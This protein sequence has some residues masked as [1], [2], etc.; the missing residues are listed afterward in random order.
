MS[1]YPLTPC[2]D[3]PDRQIGCHGKCN[4]YTS[5]RKIVDDIRR[6]EQERT[7]FDQIMIEQCNKRFEPYRKAMQRKKMRK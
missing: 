1:N 6:S 4:N 3:C 5:W 2:K 7:R